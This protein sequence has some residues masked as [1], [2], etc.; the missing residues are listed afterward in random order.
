MALLGKKAA[1]LLVEIGTEE[2]PPKALRS[3]MLAFAG[4]MRRGFDEN[5]LACDDITPFASPRR[6]AIVASALAQAQQ[7]REIEMR[8]PPVRVAFD[9]DGNPQPAAEAFAKKCGVGV[10]R[11]GR[12]ATDKGEY[13]VFRTVEKGQA[14]AALLPGLV[15]KALSELPIPRRMRWG[16][17]DAEFVRPVHWVVMLHG[18]KVV[19][20]KVLGITTSNKTRGHRFM[21]P[22]PIKLGDP[23]DYARK[24]ENDGYVIA[25][26]DQR[27]RKITAIVTQAAI[28]VGGQVAADEDLFDEV[29]ALTEWPTA[30]VGSFDQSFLS[31]PKEV[32][33]ETLTSHQRYFPIAGSK[34]SLLSDFVTVA[35][36][37]SEDPDIVR[38]GNE[39]VIRPR[40]ADA[41]FFWDTDRKT[42]LSSRRQQLEKT[43]Y[44]KGLG[45]LADKSQR[46]AA[47]AALVASRM[48]A[49]SDSAERAG[50]LAKCDLQTGMVGEFPELQGIMGRYYA[51]ADGE[52]EDVAVA[53]GEQYLP[54]FAGDDV[55]ATP[56]GQALAIADRLDTLAG[57]FALGMKP[58]G[59]RD[60]FGLR[61]AALGVFRTIVER[62]LDLN[63]NE[64][65]KAATDA[66]PPADK[67]K[68]LAI[69]LYDFIAERMRAWYA[70]RRGITT[71]MF[72]AVR[73]RRPVS[74]LDFDERLVAVSAFVRLDSA[75]SLAAANKRIANIL[76]QAD[77]SG[78][79]KIESRLFE[80]EAEKS[81]HQALQAATADI[82]PLMRK[83]AYTDA[84]ARLAELREVIDKF[85][86]EVMVMAEK[87]E[88]R[89]NRLALLSELR[90]LFLGVAD[91]SRLSIS[92]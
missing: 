84:L 74:L 66:Q 14:A 7:D 29:T 87:E 1:A 82:A 69:D 20:G 77:H 85:F 15:E 27:K 86:D 43:V 45:S 23:A 68:S 18:R 3:L 78:K 36:I 73:V 52:A 13:L 56:A 11:L 39:R 49:N 40:L 60:P 22:E 28:E 8:G 24:L 59:N 42:S 30:L 61:R 35:N 55:P 12:A 92:T 90:S 70:E 80:D 91:I 53:I 67:A 65:L 57:V 79:V 58:S 25:D 10:A 88:L 71:E 37:E 83:R 81:L 41:A 5:R 33:I 63:I 32:I 31:L 89:V 48:K 16:D 62:K 54:R 51:A 75:E 2:L 44:Q 50:L 17:S 38:A 19:P 64:I 76:R 21:A 26:F 9:D 47:L 4:N 72:E 34:G 46:I 6:L